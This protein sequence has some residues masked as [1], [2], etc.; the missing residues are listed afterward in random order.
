MKEEEERLA[1]TKKWRIGLFSILAG[2]GI[3]I[4]LASESSSTK[5]SFSQ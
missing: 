2:I 5:S 4:Y 1:Q 3:G